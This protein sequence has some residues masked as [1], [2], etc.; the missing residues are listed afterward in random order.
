VDHTQFFQVT[1]KTHSF[2]RD[3]TGVSALEP[4]VTEYAEFYVVSDE[5]HKWSSLSEGECLC[6]VSAEHGVLNEFEMM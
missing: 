2:I 3:V 5:I 4:E 6:F 1:I